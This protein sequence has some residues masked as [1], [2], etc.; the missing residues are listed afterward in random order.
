[1]PQ[2]ISQWDHFKLYKVDLFIT[3]P[4]T[5]KTNIIIVGKVNNKQLFCRNW[6]FVIRDET[7][8]LIERLRVGLHLHRHMCLLDWCLDEIR[9][10]Q[11]QRE[12]DSPRQDHTW[13]EP[14][15]LLVVSSSVLV[16]FHERQSP[17]GPWHRRRFLT[18]RT[19]DV[20]HRIQLLCKDFVIRTNQRR[21]EV[22]LQA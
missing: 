7:G 13:R 15:S 21:L 16:G 6:I 1:M 8:S 5:K 2:I 4:T 12:T 11:T 18:N 22:Q 20:R 19:M 17:S 9:H 3:L 14:I 10:P